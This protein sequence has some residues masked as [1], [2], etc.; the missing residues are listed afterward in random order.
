MVATVIVKG[1]EG[2][3]VFVLFRVINLVC[4][5]FRPLASRVRGSSSLVVLPLSGGLGSG[6]YTSSILFFKCLVG[7]SAGFRFSGARPT[8]IFKIL[9]VFSDLGVLV[10]LPMSISGSLRL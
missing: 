2:L 1:V 4:V 10:G 9:N 3:L 5:F 6:N 7:G 8:V